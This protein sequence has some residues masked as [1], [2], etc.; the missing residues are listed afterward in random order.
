MQSMPYYQQG[1]QAPYQ[2]TVLNNAPML[3]HPNGLPP[4]QH[5]GIPE[6]MAAAAAAAAGSTQAPK[7]K[8]VKNACTN[9]QKACKKCDDARPCPRCIKYGIAD[10]C[11]NSVRKERKKGIKRGPY[12]RRQKTED[13][14]RKSEDPNVQAAQYP[15]AMRNAIPFGYPSNLNQYGQP[16]DPYSQYAAY[17][18]EQMMSQPYV[19]NPVYP[20]MGYPVMV[21]G[22]NEGQNHQ[23]QQQQP[24][25]QQNPQQQQQQQ[26]P[27]Q[28][29]QQQQVTSNQQQPQQHPYP[30]LMHQQ[31]PSPQAAAAAVAMARPPLIQQHSE[32]Y[33]SQVYYQHQ[34]QPPQQQQPQPSQ[35]QQSQSQSASQRNSPHLPDIKSDQSQPQ[36]T[37][38]FNKSQ[39]MATPST[40]TSTATTSSPDSASWAP[41]RT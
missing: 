14:T 9:C 12:K 37:Q 18:K 24:Q 27:Q 8:Q 39:T 1:Y 19:V 25:S 30:Y 4:M 29:Q 21:T 11:V 7:R 2:N 34:Q 40:S 13:K 17:H 5:A 22:S 3:T 20:P 15:P 6:Q 31:Q 10:T 23:Q 41:S 28:Q 16:Y 33:P 35:P 32:H 26:Q 36:Q 38:E